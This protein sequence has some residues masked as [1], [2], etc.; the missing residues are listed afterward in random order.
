[1]QSAPM[2]S[3]PNS[4]HRPPRRASVASFSTL[5][6]SSQGRN[7]QSAFAP[8]KLLKTFTRALARAERPGASTLQHFLR[9][10]FAAGARQ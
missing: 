4:P 1:M 10:T 9:F 7:S 6:S 3:A 8:R 5:P 2:C